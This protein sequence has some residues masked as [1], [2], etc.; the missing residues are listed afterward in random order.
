LVGTLINVGAVLAGGTIGSLV[1]SR[2][3]IGIRV[4]L[5]QAI[6]LA[7]LVI[8]LQRVLPTSNVLILLGSMLLGVVVGE[9]LRIEDRLE[10]VGGLAER[11]F[12]VKPRVTGRTGAGSDEASP[13][14]R[15]F[16]TASLIFCVGPMT[17]LG[18]FEDGL[19]SSYQTLA[20]KSMLDGI[21][22]TVLSSSLGWGV[23][24]AAVTV[25]VFQG[26][27]TLG[28]GLLR[29]ML[30]EPMIVE[31]TAVGGLLI[32]GIGLNILELSRIRVG[33]MLPAL[34]FAPVLVAITGTQGSP[35][36]VLGR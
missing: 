32:L 5:M 16:V 12:G 27:L 36:V 18:S 30:S 1:G 6:G 23:L 35:G 8:G 20:I 34:V 22:A 13:V 28:A 15:G 2:F 33:N 31:M 10:A 7:T 11:T 24:L 3:P 21:T 4:T 17:I 19:S 14:A 25:L 29:S 26:T 9:L